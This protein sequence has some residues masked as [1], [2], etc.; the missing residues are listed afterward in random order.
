MNDAI[1]VN[2]QIHHGPTGEDLIV[3]AVDGDNIYW[4][5]FPFGGF[6]KREDCT[7]MSKG[8]E[9]GREELIQH[10]AEMNSYERPCIMARELLAQRRKAS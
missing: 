1:E 5:G 7:L 2:D 8:S 10:L 4:C 9:E 6:V 3:A